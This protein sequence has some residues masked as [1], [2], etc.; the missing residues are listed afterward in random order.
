MP[1]ITVKAPQR[2]H[3][4]SIEEILFADVQM[5]DFHTGYQKPNGDTLTRYTA[6]V[7][8]E[9]IRKMNIPFL[10]QLLETFNMNTKP[11][12]EVD[13][14]ELYR[15]FQIPK[16]S[17]GMRTIN[18]PNAA[19][20]EALRSLEAIL[21]V[22]FKASHH[23]SAFAYVEHRAC[24]DAVKRHQGN[25]S[26]WFLKTDFSDFFGSTS[27][28]FLMHA[29]SMIFPFDQVIM[30]QNGRVQ[31]EKALELC[32]LDGGLPQGTPISPML[33]NLMMI[34]IDHKLNKVL[35][36]KGFIYTRYADDILISHKY[37]FKYKEIV[38]LINDTVID[39]GAPFRIKP[40]KTRYGSSSGRNWNL[41]LMLNREN[42]I[43]I[44]WRAKE[45]LR[46]A[47]HNYYMGHQ[48]G[49]IRMEYEEVAK[50]NGLL[51][52]YFGIEP[53]YVRGALLHFAK[54]HNHIN[55]LKMIRDELSGKL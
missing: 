46:A 26:R 25:E 53:N 54:T 2:T 30:D 14:H 36:Q 32:F 50:L 41:G 24:I 6:K 17:G 28:D 5:S 11:L 47:L 7:N 43:T 33:T 34:P 15:T 39:A 51:S 44:G 4:V 20:S 1:F 18:A 42:K 48:P 38:K 27:L 55:V 21:V 31:L 3:Q 13:R 45:R 49:N 23:T 9:T 8:P 12:H 52:Y 35:R 37:D 16:K 19:L 22:N 29:L 10:I 40:T